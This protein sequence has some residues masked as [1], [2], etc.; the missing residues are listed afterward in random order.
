MAGIGAEAPR[1]PLVEAYALQQAGRAPEA[2]QLLEALLADYP[3]CQYVLRA[4]GYCYHQVGRN[5]D[6]SRVFE[7]AIED[8]PNAEMVKN[9]FYFRSQIALK[10]LDGVPPNGDGPVFIRRF[11]PD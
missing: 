4:L 9:Y 3:S 10:I 8:A 2:I 5:V 7:R 1:A 6:A 11:D